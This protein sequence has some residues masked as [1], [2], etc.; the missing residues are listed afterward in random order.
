ME[1]FVSYLRVSLCC[2]VQILVASAR[3][4]IVEVRLTCQLENELPL[5]CMGHPL[6]P[7][8]RLTSH[9]IGRPYSAIV[10]SL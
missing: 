5:L 2:F 3:I 8:E 9:A 4:Q 1:L 10:V 6:L 7:I